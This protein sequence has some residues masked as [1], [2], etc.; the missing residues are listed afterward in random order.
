VN[1]TLWIHT[2]RAFTKVKKN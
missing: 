1:R 2:C